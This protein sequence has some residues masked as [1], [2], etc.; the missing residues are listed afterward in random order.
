MAQDDS[1]SRLSTLRCTGGLG[2]QAPQNS[3]DAK[4]PSFL[5]RSCFHLSITE[6]TLKSACATCSQFLLS[7]SIGSGAAVAS[8]APKSVRKPRCIRCDGHG[9]SCS[10][11]CVVQ[12]NRIPAAMKLPGDIENLTFFFSI[13]LPFVEA[14]EVSRCRHQYDLANMTFCML[15]MGPKQLKS[16]PML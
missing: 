10:C 6:I 1:L 5:V 12:N 13:C 9:I 2:A 7:C 8:T 11:A 4:K 14:F 16:V 15:L 3:D